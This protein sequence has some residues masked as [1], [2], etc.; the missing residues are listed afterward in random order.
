MKTRKAQ[1]WAEIPKINIASETLRVVF[2][3]WENENEASHVERAVLTSQQLFNANDDP[4]D[5][6]MTARTCL[7][8]VDCEYWASQHESPLGFYHSEKTACAI[9]APGRILV[10]HEVFLR[11][12]FTL[13]K[14]E[15]NECDDESSELIRNIDV[16]IQLEG[17]GELSLGLRR[18]ELF[19]ASYVKTNSWRFYS[20]WSR[21]G[22]ATNCFTP[23]R[24]LKTYSASYEKNERQL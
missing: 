14:F 15:E 20:C 9:E 2:L 16:L 22:K 7:A 24:N 8:V 18:E 11:H 13:E 23:S 3:S 1:L 6:S 5:R 12:S 19:P 10:F 21:L 17:K 4:C